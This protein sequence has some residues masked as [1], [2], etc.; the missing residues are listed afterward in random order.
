MEVKFE[1]GKN[2]AMKVPPHQ[3]DATIAF[4]RDV[5]HFEAIGVP[6][7]DAVSFKFEQINLWIDRAVGISQAELWLE[8]LTNDTLAAATS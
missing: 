2:I 6:N 4:Y 7:G 5:L 1:G 3:Y 8:I